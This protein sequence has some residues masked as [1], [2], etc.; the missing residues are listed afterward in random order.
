MSGASACEDRGCGP[1]MGATSREKGYVKRPND[2]HGG[3]HKR[4][5][6]G[7][8]AGTVVLWSC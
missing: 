6:G 7:F 5:K 2:Q 4:T 1:E 8:G 3:G